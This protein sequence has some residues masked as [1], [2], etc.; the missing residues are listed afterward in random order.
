M[1]QAFLAL[2]IAAA[3]NISA[4]AQNTPVCGVKVNEVCRTSN[5]RSYCYKTNFAYNYSVCKNN[6]G[7]T[8][9][10]EAPNYYNSTHPAFIVADGKAGTSGEAT[11]PETQYYVM[12]SKTSP[13]QHH[14]SGEETACYMGNNAAKLTRNPYKGCPSPQYDG[15]EDNR[16]RNVNVANPE[17]MPPLAGIS[18]ELH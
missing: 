14:T 11:A 17:P 6:N 4:Q 7:Y 16:R 1:K 9:C 15:P 5:N 3:G 13:D 18:A 12:H 2:M 10:C 8:I